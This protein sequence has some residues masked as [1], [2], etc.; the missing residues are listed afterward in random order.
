MRIASADVDSGLRML[1][2]WSAWKVL[3]SENGAR[4]SAVA[5][6]KAETYNR[7]A[8]F[9]EFAYSTTVTCDRS[10]KHVWVPIGRAI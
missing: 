8:I 9:A 4:K 5:D 2:I 1:G 7:T 6:R 10:L 3:A